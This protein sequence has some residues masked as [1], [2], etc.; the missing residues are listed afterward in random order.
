[1]LGAI[2]SVGPAGFSTIQTELHRNQFGRQRP[3]NRHDGGVLL[4]TQVPQS[5]PAS[6]K[7]IERN[8]QLGGGRLKM[9]APGKY[10]RCGVRG[11]DKTTW[12]LPHGLVT[13]DSVQG[14]LEACLWGTGG[15]LPPPPKY[16][17]WSISLYLKYYPE[18]L[19]Y[20]FPEKVYA[21]PQIDPPPSENLQGVMV[22]VWR[23]VS[24]GRGAD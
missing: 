15:S 4:E 10:I 18:K 17:Y 12:T 8:Q 11:N 13:I 7:K 16:I 3:G 24:V 2:S 14:V 22:W 23:Y 20:L 5:V 9:F 6:R 21:L 19:Q 1:M